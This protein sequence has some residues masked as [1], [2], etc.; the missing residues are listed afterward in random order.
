M[1][2]AKNLASHGSGVTTR[3]LNAGFRGLE[4]YG[5][6]DERG[7]PMRGGRAV[8]G[9]AATTL[10]GALAT[11]LSGCSLVGGTET[12]ATR[13]TALPTPSGTATLP[14][15]HQWQQI[16]SD[17]VAFAI[18]TGWVAFQSQDSDASLTLTAD[19]LGI[20]V[21]ELR[22][23]L[24]TSTLAQSRSTDPADPS[25][26]NVVAVP[27][28]DLPTSDFVVKA[29]ESAGIEDVSVQAVPTRFGTAL[30]ARG[31]RVVNG[32]SV[33]L[34][35]MFVDVGPRLLNITLTSTKADFLDAEMAVIAA[36]IHRS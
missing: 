26:L 11:T 4:H 1:I 16:G 20:T 15:G 6:D 24:P 17:A 32:A 8:R 23:M 30:V 2:C 31:G 35:G 7:R 18:P 21:E 27:Q 14:P 36:T 3:P 19:A 13:T 25:N 9:L 12:G 34:R 33:G 22:A 10:V 5:G 29:L 28:A